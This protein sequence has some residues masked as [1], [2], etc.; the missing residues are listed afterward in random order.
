MGRKLEGSDLSPCLCIGV[1]R[2]T[3]RE[4]GNAPVSSEIFISFDIGKTK[5]KLN[6]LKIETGIVLIS[7]C[8]IFKPEIILWIS[9][10]VTGFRKKELGLMGNVDGL[11]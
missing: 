2:A 8:T 9:S 10:G 3:L 6:F 4:F 5:T 1:T 7:V 11:V